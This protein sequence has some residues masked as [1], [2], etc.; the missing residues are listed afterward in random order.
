MRC[1]M[2]ISFLCLHYFG[3]SQQFRLYS[4]KVGDSFFISVHVPAD[5]KTQPD[6][7]YPVVFVLDGNVYFDIFS[8][9]TDQYA[10]IG[11]LQPVILVG[12]GYKDLAGMDS[13]RDRD[14]T[15]PKALPKYEMNASGGADKFLSFITKELIPNI[16]SNYKTDTAQRVLMGHSLG[17]LFTSYALLQHLNGK[18]NSFQHYIP[19]SPSLNYNNYYWLKELNKVAVAKLK[20]VSAYFCFGS[21]EDEED[22]D[23]PGMIKVADVV[24]QL[25]VFIDRNK[26]TV[27]GKAV[28][29]SSLGHMDT[30]IPGFIKGMQLALP[31]E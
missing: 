21:L 31:V 2:I 29:Y 8:A 25:R 14:Y 20:K 15:Y 18:D 12:V 16:D 6:K 1:I 13:L 28:V 9:I 23:E 27:K 11:L 19:A 24:K 17:G 10:T 5:Y 30:A 26:A 7:K 22:A 4:D 3:N